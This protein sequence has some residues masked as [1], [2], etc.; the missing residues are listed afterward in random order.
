MGQPRLMTPKSALSLSHPDGESHECERV[1]VLFGIS[2]GEGPTPMSKI[3]AAGAGAEDE[4]QGSLFCRPHTNTPRAT[5][6]RE[7]HLPSFLFPLRPL[8]VLRG[9]GHAMSS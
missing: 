9:G 4:M 8:S 1:G 6:R 2:G 7:A 5:P 3:A